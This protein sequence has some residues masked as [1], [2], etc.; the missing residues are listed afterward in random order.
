MADHTI[1]G[2]TGNDPSGAAITGRYTYTI[3]GNWRNPNNTSL[4]LARNPASGTAGITINLDSKSNSQI[5][6]DDI[7]MRTI[8]SAIIRLF[9]SAFTAVNFALSGLSSR[10]RGYIFGRRPSS[11]LLYPRGYYNK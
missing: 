3:W 4:N 1:T 11:G 9:D 6:S 7:S 8:M 5:D 10:T 2:L